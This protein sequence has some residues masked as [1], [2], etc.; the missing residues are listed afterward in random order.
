MKG[1]EGILR[2]VAVFCC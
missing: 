1:N 2:L